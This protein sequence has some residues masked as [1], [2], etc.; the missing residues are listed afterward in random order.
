[1]RVMADPKHL[2]TEQLAYYK[3]R[4]AEYDRSLRPTDPSSAEKSADIS[5][6]WEQIGAEVST[7]P[8]VETRLRLPV[9]Q[10]CGRS[11]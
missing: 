3:A 2:L 9:A 4:A 6:E 7:L 8:R 1:M 10:A 5:R 11:F